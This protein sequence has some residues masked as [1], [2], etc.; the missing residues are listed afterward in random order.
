MTNKFLNQELQDSK[1]EALDLVCFSH[2]R[3]NFVYQRPQ[4]LMSRSAKER[5][6]FFIEEPVVSDASAHMAV[7]KDRTGVF[8]VT[9][10]LPQG[11][12]EGETHTAMRELVDRF[13]AE[14]I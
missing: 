3:W 7:E 9:P 4:H 11:L 8:V 14:Q 2:L 5:R 6:V 10:H 12:N 1:Q 13:F